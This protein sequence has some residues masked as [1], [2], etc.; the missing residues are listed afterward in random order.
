[1]SAALLILLVS[2]PTPF[3]WLLSVFSLMNVVSDLIPFESRVGVSDGQRLWMLLRRRAAGERW[4]ALLGLGRELDEGVLPESLST[5]MLEKALA[6]RDASV[7]TVVAHS[8]GYAVAFHRRK[9]DEAAEML[10]TSL[11]HVAH[12][13][14]AVRDALISDAAVF[15]AK[16][17]ARPDLAEQWL[18]EMPT[19]ALPWLRARAEAAILESRGDVRGAKEK[20]AAVEAAILQLPAGGRRD[21]SMTLLRRWEAQLSNS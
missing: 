5:E 20:L 21:S 17:R 1:V 7:D 10:E 4:L 8:I 14:P 3:T 19:H 15:Q 2:P 16:R 13:S 11:G 12:A 6:V 18:R 9:D